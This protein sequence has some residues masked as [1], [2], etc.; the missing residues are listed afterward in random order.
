MQVVHGGGAIL[1]DTNRFGRA[2]L[3]KQVLR[4][5]L[6]AL[7]ANS[8]HHENC[9][10]RRQYAE[11]ILSQPETATWIKGLASF[12]ASPDLPSDTKTL[13]IMTALW[14]WLQRRGIASNFS[15]AREA[16]VKAD[17]A[18]IMNSPD[19]DDLYN[20]T[21]Y[22]LMALV[23]VKVAGNSVDDSHEA[24]RAFDQAITDIVHQ[25]RYDRLTID[26][27]MSALAF[28]I[29]WFAHD[30]QLDRAAVCQSIIDLDSAIWDMLAPYHPDGEETITP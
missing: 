23:L 10:K 20:G 19:A 8:C 2:R 13:Q 9:N 30:L 7:L 12:G 3:T 15:Q 11:R 4:E 17:L 25:L 22:G 1:L 29:A 5:V 16:T 24:V 18:K 21:V 14:D 28:E 6:A 26:Q 27:T